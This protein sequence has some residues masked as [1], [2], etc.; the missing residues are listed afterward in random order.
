MLL[1]NVLKFLR[2]VGLFPRKIR[3]RHLGCRPHAAEGRK[4]SHIGSF[5][6]LILSATIVYHL[7]SVLLDILM[8][9]DILRTSK[10]NSIKGI[11]LI[12]I[13]VWHATYAASFAAVSLVILLKNK[14]LVELYNLLDRSHSILSEKI[15]F[16][17]V[18]WYRTYIIFIIF[19]V[20]LGQMIFNITVL[21]VST[22]YFVVWLK[23][24]IDELAFELLV[25]SIFLNIAL[26]HRKIITTE[27]KIFNESSNGKM[28]TKNY[29]F[30]VTSDLFSGQKSIKLKKIMKETTFTYAIAAQTQEMLKGV[31]KF[32][33]LAM[34]ILG[35]AISIK[36]IQ[37]SID[38]TATV[39]FIMR[40]LFTVSKVRTTYQIVIASLN[41][42][43]LVM[44][45]T[46][47]DSLNN[48][49][50]ILQ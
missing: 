43:R 13:A 15:D 4:V 36:I 10:S 39:Y 41:I 23:S 20:A 24:E 21:V 38:L 33:Y 9:N 31:N 14:K 5:S 40:N 37:K 25:E 27:G 30:L 46:L 3:S 29:E 7:L 28:L 45:A 8:V 44:L 34:N 26:L 6:P 48:E 11:D 32:E 50:R 12:G 18:S 16:P 47:P 2:L 19:I 49:V 1:L 42:L 17:S 22:P 35:F